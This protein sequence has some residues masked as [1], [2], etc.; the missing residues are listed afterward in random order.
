MPTSESFFRAHTRKGSALRPVTRRL[1]NTPRG[2][3]SPDPR[4]EYR[5]SSRPALFGSDIARA[6]RQQLQDARPPLQAR[7]SHAHEGVKGL[8]LYDC[9][10]GCT[11]I[12][13][14]CRIASTFR[15]LGLR[16]FEVDK[17]VFLTRSLPHE[18]FVHSRTRSYT[19]GTGYFPHVRLVIP[20]ARGEISVTGEGPDASHMYDWPPP[21]VQGGISVTA[22]FS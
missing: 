14:R 10:L 5:F 3:I 1:S 8:Q 12:C 20:S 11:I 4:L 17:V 16:F 2:R 13:H 19:Q 6:A 15:C 7:H 9:F 22:V 21:S 18:K